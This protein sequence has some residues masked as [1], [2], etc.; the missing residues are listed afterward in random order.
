M[1]RDDHGFDCGMTYCDILVLHI[2]D[3]PCAFHGRMNLRTSAGL[4]LAVGPSTFGQRAVI[5]VV[6][7]G[8]Q[9]SSTTVD[10]EHLKYLGVPF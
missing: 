5:H 6:V 4:L 1:T 10:Q 8:L 3:T 7:S 2:S 9:I